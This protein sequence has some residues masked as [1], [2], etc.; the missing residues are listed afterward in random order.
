MLQKSP[1]ASNVNTRTWLVLYPSSTM[2]CVTSNC[3]LYVLT[4]QRSYSDPKICRCCTITLKADV[5]TTCLCFPSCSSCDA[6]SV[7][8]HS[9]QESECQNSLCVLPSH[10]F[11]SVSSSAIPPLNCQP[12][13]Q[14][15]L[16]F[17]TGSCSIANTWEGTDGPV[18]PC[19]CMYY[20]LDCATYLP[21]AELFLLSS[22]FS[23]EQK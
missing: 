1:H 20:C 13:F 4:S 12:T 5:N 16:Q 14:I 18:S 11:R 6:K 10:G 15:S 2:L 9:R 8:C 23:Q 22:L 21:K 7:P 19:M 17:R 3:T